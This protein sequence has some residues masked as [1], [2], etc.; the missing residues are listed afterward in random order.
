MKLLKRICL[1]AALLAGFSWLSGVLRDRQT[2]SENLVRLHVVGASNSE[3]DQTAKLAVRD[4]LIAQYGDL[5]AGAED[6][7]QA[8][9]LLGEQLSALEAAANE[10][11]L[12]AGSE[13]TAT[14]QLLREPFSARD[15]DTFSLP[16]GVYCSL[17]VTIGEG[18]GKNWWCVVFPSLC[19]ATD[20]SALADSAAG[21]GFSEELTATLTHEDGHELRFFVLDALGWVQNWLFGRE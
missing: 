16:A 6:A 18:E 9:A 19:M 15:Y 8:Q 2:L 12:A 11:L 4:A 13:D 5:L 1:L 10:A 3:A 17:R 7:Q 14:V 21:A 20:S